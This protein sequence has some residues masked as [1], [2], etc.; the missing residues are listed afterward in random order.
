MMLIT[1]KVF[2]AEAEAGEEKHQIH[3]VAPRLDPK[4][5]DMEVPAFISILEK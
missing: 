4:N 2:E 3:I 5:K 1:C